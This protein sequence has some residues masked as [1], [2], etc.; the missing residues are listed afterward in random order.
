MKQ[1]FLLL[2]IAF[3]LAF[4]SPSLQLARG[5]AGVPVVRVSATLSRTSERTGQLAVMA[6]IKKGFHIYAQSQPRPFLATKISVAQSA[7]VR[8]TGA[9]TP[10]RPPTIVM[11]PTIQVELHEYEGQ[12]MWTAPVEFLSPS[13][14]DMVV[15]GTLF[16]QA[17]AE[18]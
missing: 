14:G 3:G 7:S 16:A 15:A 6:D 9:F 2:S 18:S 12:V 8:V 10:S 4:V 1:V 11:H 5:D 13:D 17:C